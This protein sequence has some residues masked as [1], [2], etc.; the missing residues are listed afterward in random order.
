MTGG[1]ELKSFVSSIVNNLFF[2]FAFSLKS[3]ASV[4]SL[5]YTLIAYAPFPRVKETVVDA[6]PVEA[7]PAVEAFVEEAYVEET[8]AEAAPVE[9]APVEEAPAEEA[10]VEEVTIDVE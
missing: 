6:D 2:L 5:L 3:F 9:E 1:K 8:Y 4:F 10:P 7:A